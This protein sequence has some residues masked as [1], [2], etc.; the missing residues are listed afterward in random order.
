MEF[1]VVDEL[2]ELDGLVDVIAVRGVSWNDWW[3]FETLYYAHYVDA[4]GAVQQIGGLKIAKVDHEYGGTNG[5]RTPLKSKFSRLGNQYVS[6]GQDESYY[7]RLRDLL[8]PSKSKAALK[9]LGDLAISPQRFTQ[10][11]A[12]TVVSESLLRSVSSVTVRGVYAKIIQ[13]NDQPTAFDFTFSKS[14]KNPFVAD[15]QVSLGFRVVPDSM[16]PTNIHVLIGR[17]GSGKTTLLRSMARSMIGS[18][19]ERQDDGA[20]HSAIEGVDGQFANLVYVAFSAFDEVEVPVRDNP[21]SYNV[22]YSYIGLQYLADKLPLDATE[23]PKA[24]KSTRPASEL[25]DVFAT[26]AWTIITGKSMALWRGA[27]DILEADPNFAAAD[28]SQLADDTLLDKLEEKSFKAAARVLYTERLSSGHRIVLL[29]ITRLVETVSERTLVLLDEPEGHLHP[30]LLSAFVRALSG[31]LKARNGLAIVA[32]HSPVILQ[33]APRSCVYSINRSG[34][35]QTAERPSL[36][37]FGENVGTLTHAVFGLE[38]LAT[39]FS[40]LL[41]DAATGAQSYELVSTAFHD[42]LGFEAR[43][44]IRTWLA[45]TSPQTANAEEVVWPD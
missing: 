3:R 7:K 25:A 36:E 1:Y 31:L 8:G 28:V 37:T 41:R 39:G 12:E 16:P 44:L 32:T 35:V 38:V 4:Q 20:F 18:P 26:S 6:L 22:P 42:E 29:T 43:A 23:N 40:Q 19:F 15:R 17:N 13:G 33:E 27:L 10:F 21:S 34:D 5:S 2:K 11:H 14:T 45:Q 9:S 24:R 30:P